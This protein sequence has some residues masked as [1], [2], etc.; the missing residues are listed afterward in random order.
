MKIESFCLGLFMTN[1]Y[2]VYDDNK[3]QAV[4]IDPGQ[5]PTQLIARL[6][7]LRLDVQAILLTHAHLDHIAGLNEVR[8][9]TSAPVYLHEKEADWLQDP[10]KNG[11]SRWPEMPEIVCEPADVLLSGGEKLQ[12]FGNA[13]D[14]IYTPGHSPG[15]VSFWGGKQIFSGDVLFA[16]SIGRTDLLGGD[17]NQLMQTIQTKMLPLAVDTVVYPGHGP[18]TTIAVEKQQNP[19]LA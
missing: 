3:R 19:Y 5:S 8:K 17:Y 6:Q 13:F 2:L 7:E 12:F 18:A 16:G 15:S 10:D 14:V 11:S 9:L 4:V 1:A